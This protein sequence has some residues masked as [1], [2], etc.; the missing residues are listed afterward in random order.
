MSVNNNPIFPAIIRVKG[1]REPIDVVIEDNDGEPVDLTG[2]TIVTN[3]WNIA[4]ETQK[5]TNGACT[6]TSATAGQVRYAPAA[7]DVDTVGRFAIYFTDTSV[8]PNRDYPYD[9]ARLTMRVVDRWE[10]Q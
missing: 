1:N 2:K 4:A 6:I 7:A 9:G 3:W 5:V 8:T 10:A